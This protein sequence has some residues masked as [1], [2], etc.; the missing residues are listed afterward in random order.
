MLDRG[1]LELVRSEVNHVGLEPLE[2]IDGLAAAVIRGIVKQKDA[3]LP[4]LGIIDV[5][6]LGKLD[7]EESHRGRSSGPLVH[8]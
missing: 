7:K 4:P 1:H 6:P 5:K 2:N 3:P 8:C